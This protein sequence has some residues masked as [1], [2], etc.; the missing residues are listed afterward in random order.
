MV[1]NFDKL[2]DDLEKQEL[3]AWVQNNVPSV[4][5]YAQ[6]LA[7]YL[8]QNDLC[9]AKY[10]WKRIPQNV[11][12]THSE[13]LQIWSV[14]QHMW[15]RDYQST[16]STLST[17]TWP[18]YIKDIMKSLLDNV[19]ERAINLIQQSYSSLSINAVSTMTG[20]TQDDIKNNILS[21]Y[22]WTLDT[23]DSNIIILPTIQQQQSLI[24]NN[25]NQTLTTSSE[26]QL[27]KLTEFVSFLEN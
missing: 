18:E 12:N 27:Y 2:G 6:L 7:V 13:L 5:V 20:L 9:N 19:R 16:Y 26:D 8:Y 10:L 4:Q 22:H 25:N 15:K 23:T 24:N 21:K 11:K 1:V 17:T 14:G 3:E